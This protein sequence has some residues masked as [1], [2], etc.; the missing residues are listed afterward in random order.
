[1]NFKKRYEKLYK[2]AALFRTTVE[3]DSKHFEPTDLNL[4]KNLNTFFME[5][6]GFF[7]FFSFLLTSLFV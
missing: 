3:S 1:M 6:V 7:S 5:G 2:S 4:L